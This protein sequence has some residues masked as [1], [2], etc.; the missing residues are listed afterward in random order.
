MERMRE[1]LRIMKDTPKGI[2][3][4]PTDDVKK[5]YITRKSLITDSYLSELG[6]DKQTYTQR[7]L[8]KNLQLIGK[9][10]E[11]IIE[12]YDTMYWTDSTYDTLIDIADYIYEDYIKGGQDGLCYFSFIYNNIIVFI[13]SDSEIS[14]PSIQFK[15]VKSQ[16]DICDLDKIKKPFKFLSAFY[17]F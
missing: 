5:N 3:I 13:E 1:I 11:C 4:S 8:V 16:I 10:P 7:E 6:L 15:Y 2:C 17:T 12:K 14:K 9:H